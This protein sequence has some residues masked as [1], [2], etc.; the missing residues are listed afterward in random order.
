M[1]QWISMCLSMLAAPVPPMPPALSATIATFKEQNFTIQG[2][3]SV[4]SDFERAATPPRVRIAINAAKDTYLVELPHSAVD[5]TPDTLNVVITA[6][7]YLAQQA[8]LAEGTSPHLSLRASI[9]N[10]TGWSSWSPATAV[11]IPKNL[12]F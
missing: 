6:P 9:R 12:G 11:L 8:W 2:S 3:I 7:V 1:L 5:A 4:R 10:G